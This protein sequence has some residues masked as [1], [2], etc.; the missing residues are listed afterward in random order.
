MLY[1][2][3]SFRDKNDYWLNHEI[4]LFLFFDIEQVFLLFSIKYV[5]RW[6]YKERKKERKKD[7]KKLNVSGSFMIHGWN[8]LK[9][10][11]NVQITKN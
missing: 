7:R 10:L 6:K 9:N 8:W 1:L 4:D 5:S 11:K 2:K 3:V